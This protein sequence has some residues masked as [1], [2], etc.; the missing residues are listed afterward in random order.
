MLKKIRS[1]DDN[2]QAGVLMTRRTLK[3]KPLVEAIFEL[4]W[5]LQEPAPI[6]KVDPHYRL[7][8]GRVYDRVK[9]EYPFHEQLPT[10]TIPDEI[11]GYVVQHRFRKDKDEWP[12]IQVGPGVI[13]LNDTDGYIWEDFEK[14]I[15]H[16]LDTFFEAYPNT[17]SKITINRSLLRYIDAVSFDYEEGD[18]FTFLREKMKMNIE[19]N[20]DLFEKTEVSRLPLGLDMRF[21]F[22]SKEPKG[23]VHLRFSRGK[24]EDV[25]ALLWETMVESLG[26]DSPQTKK[27]ITTWVKKAHQ[28]TDNWFFMMIEGELLRR[29]E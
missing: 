20:N 8:V 3:N 2:P 7:L 10:A 1:A 24:R 22:P 9:D 6:M 21:S 14:R 4:R 16:V 26:N 15:S 25:H 12:L 19:I 13:T 29:F 18:I 17:D 27:D 28:L 5:E 23:A 11:A